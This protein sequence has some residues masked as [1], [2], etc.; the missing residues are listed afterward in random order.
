MNQLLTAM[1]APTASQ[2]DRITADDAI[3]P[4]DVLYEFGELDAI[5]PLEKMNRPIMLFGSM[6]S[7]I[8]NVAGPKTAK[9]RDQLMGDS[10]HAVL[11][12]SE[13]SSGLRWCRTYFLRHG[14]E[15]KLVSEV[16]F[17]HDALSGIPVVTEEEKKSEDDDIY[18]SDEEKS[19]PTPQVY[20]FNLK[21]HNAS[22]IQSTITVLSRM[23]QLYAK[24]WFHLRR[25]VHE[26][27]LHH[28][29]VLEAGTEI[30]VSCAQLYI[31]IF[32]WSLCVIATVD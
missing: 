14:T 32:D 28:H 20:N 17:L 4:I 22:E 25:I 1:D 31:S 9:W 19:E 12:A 5:A 8:G 18:L 26:T 11:E 2:R 21:P 6:T 16:Q 7:F 23:Q 3:G 15:D 27:F 13:P 24:L 10:L 29:D 30:Q